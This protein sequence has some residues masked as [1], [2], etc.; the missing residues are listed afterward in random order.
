MERTKI[1]SSVAALIVLAPFVL[2]CRN[3]AIPDWPRAHMAVTQNAAAPDLKG[4]GKMN[5]SR[6]I[7]QEV[8]S[9]GHGAQVGLPR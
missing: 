2:A 6:I 7:K 1:C 9:N 5:E 3:E 8:E 4:K